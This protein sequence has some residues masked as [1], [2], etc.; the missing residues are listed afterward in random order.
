MLL[1]LALSGCA[2]GSGSWSATYH[3]V[4][5]PYDAPTQQLTDTAGAAYSLASSTHKPWTLVFFGYTHCPDVC[6][7]VMGNLASAMTRLSASD[8]SRVDVVFV[9]TDPARDDTGVLKRYL[10]HYDPGFVGVTGPLSRIVAIGRDLGVG[11][12]KGPRLPSGGYDVTHGAYVF[13]LDGHDKVPYY[14]RDDTSPA[15]YAADLHHLI[16][17]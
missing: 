13:A 4:P 8:R 3:D 2:S 11:I 6:G 5:T 9:T 15:Q 14:W 12:S 10:A 16:D 7:L 1:G 17:S